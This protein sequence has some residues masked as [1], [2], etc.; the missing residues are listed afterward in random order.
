V[1]TA[2]L[3]GA[4]ALAT[5]LAGALIWQIVRSASAGDARLKE[6]KERGVLERRVDAQAR[7]IE[8]RNRTIE[9][10]ESTA[11]RET[12]RSR[13]LRDQL[14]DAQDLLLQ[15]KPD[16]VGPSI[17]RALERYLELLPVP[18]AERAGPSTAPEDH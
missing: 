5:T 16:E 18:G 8:D 11:A 12:A 3:I 2:A 10:L 6:A 4:L 14:R 15:V 13:A 17:R 1:I 9:S 7:A